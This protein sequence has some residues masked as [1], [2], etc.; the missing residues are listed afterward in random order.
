[1]ARVR[2][3]FGDS[4]RAVRWTRPDQMHL[5]LKFLGDVSVG[6][7]PAVCDAVRKAAAAHGPFE[8]TVTGVGCFPKGGPVRVLWVG[9]DDA[10]GALAGMQTAVESAVEP[11]GFPREQRGFSAH[12]TLGRVKDA[13]ASAAIRRS[14]QRAAFGPAVQSV[15]EIVLFESQ[16]SPA[17]SR[18]MPVCREKLTG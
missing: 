2:D 4:D 15:D 17:G 12:L 6:Q 10:N 13:S 18:Y 7:L 16:L 1:M 9:V 8:F 3:R 11:L 5:T 14:L